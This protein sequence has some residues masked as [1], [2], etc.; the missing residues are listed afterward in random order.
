MSLTAKSYFKRSLWNLLRDW[1]PRF[2]FIC[3][4]KCGDM[5]NLFWPFCS[6]YFLAHLPL[7]IPSDV[8]GQKTWTFSKGLCHRCAIPAWIKQY[9]YLILGD[10][11]SIPISISIFYISETDTNININS[12]DFENQYQY[13]YQYLSFKNSITVPIPIL[14]NLEFENNLGLNTKV[15]QYLSAKTFSYEP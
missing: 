6:A 14:K 10:H 4:T 12:P 1:Y 9:Q 3:P 11:V 8:I 2:Q 5:K 13:R 7:C 15:L